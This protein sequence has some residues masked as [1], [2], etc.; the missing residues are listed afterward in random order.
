M[1]FELRDAFVEVTSFLGIKRSAP[2]DEV[3]H[4]RSEMPKCRLWR[5]DAYSLNFTITTLNKSLKIIRVTFV[6]EVD[7]QELSLTQRVKLAYKVG[8]GAFRKNSLRAS[9]AFYKITRKKTNS[10]CLIIS[11]IIS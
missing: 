8:S 2:S 6:C 5:S 10:K 9:P 3:T 11:E 1:T 7:S 4:G